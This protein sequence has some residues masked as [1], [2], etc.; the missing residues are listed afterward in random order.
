MHLKCFSIVIRAVSFLR[1]KMGKCA[2]QSRQKT[3]NLQSQLKPK[4]NNFAS[5]TNCQKTLSGDYV[6]HFSNQLH[7]I[8][9]VMTVSHK[10]GL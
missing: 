4:K 2:V 5:V 3:P 9:P 6:H 8:V 1:P 7:A 10:L